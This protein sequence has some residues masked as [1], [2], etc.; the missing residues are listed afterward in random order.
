MQN[1]GNA[2]VSTPFTVAVTRNGTPVT[3]FTVTSLN[4]GATTDLVIPRAESRVCATL[5]TKNPSVCRRCGSG[6]QGITVWNDVGIQV[7]VDSGHA[8]SE[9]NENNNTVTISQ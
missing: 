4:A 8:V 3:T 2:N 1:A 5:D 6:V 9:S 7:T